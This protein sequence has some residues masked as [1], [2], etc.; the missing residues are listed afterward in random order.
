MNKTGRFRAC[1]GSEGQ[2]DTRKLE[3]LDQSRLRAATDSLE[4]GTSVVECMT[5]GER[6]L[7]EHRAARLNASPTANKK[8]AIGGSNVSGLA[9]PFVLS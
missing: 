2:W 5:H 9:Q 4:N 1:T 8:A 3:G 6:Q 7:A